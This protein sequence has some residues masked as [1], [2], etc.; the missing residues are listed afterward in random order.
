M[1]K[2]IDLFSGIGGFHVALK[3]EGMDCVFACDIDRHSQ[4]AYEANFG[5]APRGDITELSASAIPQHDILCAGFPCQ[6]FSISGKKEGLADERGRLFYEIVRIAKHHR[7]L[8][9]LLENVRTILT[10]D[11]GSV[12]REIYQS[13]EGIGYRLEHVVLNASDFGIPQRRERVYFVAMRKDSPLWFKHPSPSLKEVYLKDM[14]LPDS[15]TAELVVKRDDICIELAGEQPLACKPIKVGYLNKSGQGERIY[16]T[17]GHA[18]T[19]S[20]NGGGVGSRTGLYLVNGKVR[21]LHIDE[22]KSVMGF[23]KRHIV[24]DGVNGYRQLGNAVIPA[25]INN[26]YNH[27]RISA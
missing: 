22:A 1:H 7:P 3:R 24:S 12:Q 8:L 14:L 9:M 16:S 23:D 26:I 2:F 21:R 5:L 6:P 13:L 27:V 15:E 18:I 25:M 19:L 20:A 17:N 10:I 4:E 11:N